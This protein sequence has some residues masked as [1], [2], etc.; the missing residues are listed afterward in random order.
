MVGKIFIMEIA[1]SAMW[2]AKQERIKNSGFLSGKTK[3]ALL[4]GLLLVVC[5]GIARGS[6]EEEKKKIDRFLEDCA[7]D[8]ANR[9]Y[10]P[11]HPELLDKVIIHLKRIN[12]KKLAV[13]EDW[14]VLRSLAH[15]FIYADDSFSISEKNTHL[16]KE[17]F[18]K[19][20]P[21]PSLLHRPLRITT[22]GFKLEEISEEM[23][24]F[25]SRNMEVAVYK[26]KI[27]ML[28]HDFS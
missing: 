12:E 11:G 9:A 7:T 3:R 13:P 25:G 18:C 27:H 23:N 22:S 14:S 17:L 8:F 19:L 28:I 26:T 10:V 24:M 15:I 5:M 16:L 4:I 6:V 2:L 1:S 21:L 20:E